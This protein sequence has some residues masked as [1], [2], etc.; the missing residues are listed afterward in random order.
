MRLEWLDTNSYLNVPKD[1]EDSARCFL[2][3]GEEMGEIQLAV[4][5]VIE[6]DYHENRNSLLIY[7]IITAG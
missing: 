7:F 1:E 5:R 6:S 2:K 4:G 3:N